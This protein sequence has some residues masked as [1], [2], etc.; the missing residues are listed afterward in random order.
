MK[1]MI[2][3]MITK[4]PPPPAAIPMMDII[5]RPVDGAGI[6]KV[7]VLTSAVA[8]HLHYTIE[9]MV[10]TYIFVR[11]ASLIRRNGKYRMYRYLDIFC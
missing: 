8:G 6:T 5:D 1:T 10:Q 9:T 2:T 11:N 3:V 4:P 7:L